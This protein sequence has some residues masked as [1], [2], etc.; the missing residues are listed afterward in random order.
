MSTV[1]IVDDHPIVRDGLEMMMKL[2]SDL[3][4]VA[5]ATDGVDAK[6]KLAA[7]SQLPDVILVDLQMPNMNGR[8]FIKGLAQKTKIVVLSTE[9]NAEMVMHMA[10]YGI[11][12]YLLKE[13]EP[14]KIVNEVT[15][16][17]ADDHYVAISN[18]VTAKMVQ[19]N[20]Q[21]HISHLTERQILL[22]KQV[23]AGLTNKE[24]AAQLFVTDRTIKLY[25]TEIYETLNVSN[26]AQAIAVA[27]KRGYI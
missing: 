16:V 27:A 7:L 19:W 18:A 14:D 8:D 11:H 9:I 17:I 3:T 13:E 26:R 10:D 2:T 15:K 20:Q 21:D 23:A 5:T 1:M 24:I 22:L 12:G 25:L 6:A 4:V